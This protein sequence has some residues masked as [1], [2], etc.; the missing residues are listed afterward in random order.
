MIATNRFVGGT[1]MTTKA[2]A[3]ESIK[4]LHK[5]DQRQAANC[6][7]MMIAMYLILKR[8]SILRMMVVKISGNME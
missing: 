7:I 2:L 1:L 5:I 3:A 6:A 8:V 4:N